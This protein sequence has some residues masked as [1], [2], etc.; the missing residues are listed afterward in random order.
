MY[1]FLQSFYLCTRDMFS[2]LKFHFV[3]IN[4][5]MLSVFEYFTGFGEVELSFSE[6]L[7]PE[8]TW[9]GFHLR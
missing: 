1:L 5:V 2:L 6:T 9:S 3:F 8:K 4:S 7:I